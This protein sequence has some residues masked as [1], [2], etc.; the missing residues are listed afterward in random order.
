VSGNVSIVQGTL[1][2][3]ADR[4]EVQE[5]SS[6]QYRAVATGLPS[7]PASFRQKRDRV[8]E[9]IDGHADRVDYDGAAEKVR[10]V[11]NAQLKVL[12]AGAAADEATADTI[13]YDQRADTVIFEGNSSVT[14]GLAASKAR[15]VFVPRSGLAPA[16]SAPEGSR[17]D[18]TGKPK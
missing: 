8:E 1:Q 9:F 10:L 3:K 14:P 15:L 11:G 5:L 6:G 7:Q 17:P 16:A 18:P 12:R 13:V 2:I 4:V